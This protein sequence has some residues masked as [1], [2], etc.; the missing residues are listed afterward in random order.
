VP[1]WIGALPVAYDATMPMSDPYEAQPGGVCSSWPF[2]VG[3]VIELPY[4]L[5]QD[6]TLFNLMRYRDATPWIEQ[7]RR[8]KRSFGLIQ[9]L[10]HPDRGYL[11]E[12]RNEAIYREFLDALK[13]EDRVW[14]ALPKDVAAW[15]G[16][17]ARGVEL[18]GLSVK[19]GTIVQNERS[20]LSRLSP[21][22]DD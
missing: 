18:P 9:C 22:S 20:S 8:V 4:T 14:H 15:W 7:M 11:G 19:N 3:N 17:R 21:P 13:D 10:S 16:S 12:P 1:D 6:H 5:P 2:F